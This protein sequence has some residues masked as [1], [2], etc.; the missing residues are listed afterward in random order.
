[1]GPGRT[2]VATAW[3]VSGQHANDGPLVATGVQG[4]QR[5]V[6]AGTAVDPCW[7]VIVIVAWATQRSMRFSL[8]PGGPGKVTVY[9]LSLYLSSTTL[10]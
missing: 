7:G 2:T 10:S 6:P 9:R 1:M 3:T 5:G 8:F 4:W